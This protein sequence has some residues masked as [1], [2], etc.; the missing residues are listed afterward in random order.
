MPNFDEK[1]LTVDGTHI[2]GGANSVNIK[3]PIKSL[4]KYRWN[5]LEKNVEKPIPKNIGAK[6]KNP[7]N[8]ALVTTLGPYEIQQK[9]TSVIRKTFDWG[10]GTFTY[11]NTSGFSVKSNVNFSVKAASVYGIVNSNGVWKGIRIVKEHPDN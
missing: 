7:L 4:F 9:N 2:F 5:Y 6:L 1:W 8:D 11:K 10:T 3:Q